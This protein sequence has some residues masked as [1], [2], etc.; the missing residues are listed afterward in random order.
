M[1][2]FW[3]SFIIKIA[4]NVV[5]KSV[6]EDVRSDDEEEEEE[7]KAPI[8]DVRDE[9]IPTQKVREGVQS[10]GELKSSNGKALEEHKSHANNAT[11]GGKKGR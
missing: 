6:K 11:G 8:D 3:L 9:K 2:L 5:F 7:E 4:L 1:N 10:A